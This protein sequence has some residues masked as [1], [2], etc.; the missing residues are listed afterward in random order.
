[1]AVQL[2]INKDATFLIADESGNIPDG[3]DFGLY[4]DDTRFLQRHELTLDD[5]PPVPL[6]ARATDH[7]SAT[8]F[9]TNPASPRI[10]HQLL[11]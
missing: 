3:A 5:Q 4:L 2:V 9:L 8:H 7:S 1:V 10:P 11:E 6:G